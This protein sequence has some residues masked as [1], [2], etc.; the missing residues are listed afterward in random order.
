MFDE[1]AEVF[2]QTHPALDDDIC[3]FRGFET[4]VCNRTMASTRARAVTNR[5]YARS[6]LIYQNLADSVLPCLRLA[7]A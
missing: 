2:D 1:L 3:S 5:T 4:A 6:V 7:T